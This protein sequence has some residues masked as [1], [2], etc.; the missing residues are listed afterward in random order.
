[1]VNVTVSVYVST[2]SCT[3]LEHSS[4]HL[5][6]QIPM[7]ETRDSA[8]IGPESDHVSIQSNHD[9][10]MAAV[11]IVQSQGRVPRAPPIIYK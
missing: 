1:M 10:H 2:M 6:A 9:T 3:L 8:G 7:V 11:S 5:N 4:H